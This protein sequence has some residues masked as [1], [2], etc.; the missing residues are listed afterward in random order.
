MALD[1]NSVVWAFLYWGRPFQLVSS[2]L[3]CSSPETTPIQIACNYPFS[4][5]LTRSGDAYQWELFGG[6]INSQYLETM[7][8]LDKDEST[9]VIVPDGEVVI[10]CYTWKMNA[11]PIKLPI[12]PNLPDLPMTGLPEEE[13]RKETKLIRIAS[14]GDYLV[15]LTNKGHV[16]KMERLHIT[17]ST[18][19]W[20]YVSVSA[21]MV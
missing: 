9:Q 17:G 21:Q 5:V 4:T 3:D 15:G 16:L 1:T 6:S 11:D 7:A 18:Q 13:Q 20:C 19:A 10:P 12:P 2:L 8:K 14:G